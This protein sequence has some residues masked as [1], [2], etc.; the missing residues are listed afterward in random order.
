MFTSG[1]SDMS[2]DRVS[3]A[4]LWTAATAAIRLAGVATVVVAAQCSD[5]ALA[6]DSAANRQQ[7]LTS[8][9]VCHSAEPGAPHRQGPNLNG[10]FGRKAASVDGFKYSEA[11]TRSD[12]MWD[13]QTLEGWIEDAAAALPGT[14]MNYRQRDPEK[15]KMIISYLKS[16]KP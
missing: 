6:D 3:S 9:G 16:L 4:A 15:R 14:T 11:L 12:L 7:F 2:V 8:C 13:E 10:I 1:M 5:G